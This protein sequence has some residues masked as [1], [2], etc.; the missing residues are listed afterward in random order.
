MDNSNQ[1]IDTNIENTEATV[2]KNNTNDIFLEN[3]E[4]IIITEVSS[5]TIEDNEIK[6]EETI[7]DNTEIS[8]NEEKNTPEISEEET[9]SEDI[10]IKNEDANITNCLA[11][12]IQE[13]HKLV[14]VKNVFL[15]SVRMSWKVIVSSITLAILKLLS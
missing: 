5:K 2:E 13:E 11:L 8:I 15:R 9:S 6:S 1:K 12:T 4:N 10:E 14:A 3:T 7:K